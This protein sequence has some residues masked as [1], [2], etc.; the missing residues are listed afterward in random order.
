M[1]YT[2]TPNPAID[3]NVSTS[4]VIANT[5]CRTEDAVYSPNG[6]GINVSFALKNF[7]IDSKILGFFGG[8]SGKYIIDESQKRGNES[9]P[10]W[11]D[12][13]T[14]INF[15][16]TTKRDE[17]KF[18]NS[19]PRISLQAQNELIDTIKHLN[20]LTA[21]IISGSLP[22][23]IDE[24]FYTEIIECAQNMEAEIILDIS[25]KHLKNLLSCKPLLIKP[26]LEELKDI[27]NLNISNREEIYPVMAHLHRLGAQNILLTLGNQGALFS[28]QQSIYFANAPK[29]KMYSSACAGDASLGGFLS[30][31]LNDQSEVENALKRSMAAGANTAASAGIG[32]FE[33][34]NDLIKEVKIITL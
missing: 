27:F 23:G 17:Y 5:V 30:L 21:L 9:L 26:N 29:I 15:F 13:I 24:N 14:R 31:W 32:N 12:D 19:G 4:S 3:I 11:I 6:K 33:K 2:L 1:L 25:T 18:P 34:I 7:G 20:D 10:T 16:I 8:F 28:N 22:Q